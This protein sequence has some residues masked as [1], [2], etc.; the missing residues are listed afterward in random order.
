LHVMVPEDMMFPV[1]LNVQA[2]MVLVL[3]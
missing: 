1:V 3:I 2:A